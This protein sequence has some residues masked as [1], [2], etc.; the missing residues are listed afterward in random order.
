MH[1][2]GGI[3]TE[4]IAFE[5]PVYSPLSKAKKIAYGTFRHHC[6]HFTVFAY[7]QMQIKVYRDCLP[8]NLCF[9]WRMPFMY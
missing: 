9:F 8:N 6:R 3:S 2:T 4:K 7:R 5:V 1:I